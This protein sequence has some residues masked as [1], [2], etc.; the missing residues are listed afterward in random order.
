MKLTLL[1]PNL[2]TKRE[3]NDNVQSAMHDVYILLLTSSNWYL[4]P[5]Y[6]AIMQYIQL[7]KNTLA[8]LITGD[9][10]QGV[11]SEPVMARMNELAQVINTLEAKPVIQPEPIL[12]V[13]NEF[14]SLGIVP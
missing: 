11:L 12:D 10:W 13:P 2:T 8:T 14:S 6:R 9:N 4:Q 3:Q 5:Q 7:F 1:N